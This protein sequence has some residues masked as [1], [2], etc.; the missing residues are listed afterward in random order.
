MFGKVAIIDI[1]P[2]TLFSVYALTRKSLDVRFKGVNLGIY[3][4]SYPVYSGKLDPVTQ[5]FYL[6][7]DIIIIIIITNALD[8]T[9]GGA[10]TDTTAVREREK[11]Q[12]D[13]GEPVLLTKGVGSRISAHGTPKSRNHV[14]GH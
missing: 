1:A 10:P 7:I 14:T 3:L 9:T 2:D 4:Q 12:P 5:L 6:D 11:C 8:L 13:K